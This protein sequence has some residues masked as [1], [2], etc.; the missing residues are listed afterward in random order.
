MSAEWGGVKCAV[1]GRTDGRSVGRSLHVVV[2]VQYRVS[3]CAPP[4]AP[5]VCCCCCCCA[6]VRACPVA[7]PRGVVYV[8]S[9]ASPPPSPALHSSPPSLTQSVWRAHASQRGCSLALAL[10]PTLVDR[11]A[12][13]TG[14]SWTPS[15]H[16]SSS[17]SSRG[18]VYRNACVSIWLLRVC[19]CATGV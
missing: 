6:C 3:G 18:T 7:L 16:C 19:V 1:V 10:G 14:A 17:T 5:L 11:S 13:A 12:L 4:P 8:F 9:S 15:A 2:V